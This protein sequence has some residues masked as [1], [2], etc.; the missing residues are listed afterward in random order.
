[1]SQRANPPLPLELCRAVDGVCDRFDEAWS[2]G[3]RPVLEEYL[4]S[5]PEAGRPLLRAELIRTELEWRFRREEQPSL[6]DY[7]SRFPDLQADLDAWLS[8]AQAASTEVRKVRETELAAAAETS[9]WRSSSCR[10]PCVARTIL[11]PVS[12]AR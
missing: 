1:M 12:Y 2:Q 10:P 8:E 6:N 9:A 5:V 4:D 3:Q 7:T 11:L